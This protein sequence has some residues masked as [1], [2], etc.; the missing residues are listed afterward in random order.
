MIVE[1]LP[2]IVTKLISMANEG[3][4]AAARY[5]IDRIHGRPD[6]VAAAPAVDSSLTYTHFDIA[7]DQLRR[8]AEQE[9]RADFTLFKLNR[10]KNDRQRE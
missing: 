10:L 1:A 6:R 2:G 7:A 5:L 8:K 3:N 4:M 9:I